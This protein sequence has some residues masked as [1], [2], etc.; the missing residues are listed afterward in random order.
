MAN[1]L[2]VPIV[3]WGKKPPTHRISSIVITSDLRTVVTGC[4]DGQ[5][6]VWDYKDSSIIP[7]SLLFGHSSC[8]VSIATLCETSSKR[9]IISASDVGELCMWDIDDG[10]CIEQTQLPG[11]PV[12][13]HCCSFMLKNEMQ[14]CVMCYGQFSEICL[15]DASSLQIILNL[16]SRIFPD[17]M[18]AVVV[19]PYHLT[20]DTC[21]IIG[22]TVSGMLKVWHLHKSFTQAVL[23]EEES[24]QI[25]SPMA[26]EMKFSQT[27]CSLLI[28]C[29]N[30]WL[31]CD[32][33]DYSTL[34]SEKVKH[35]QQLIGGDFLLS[36]IIITWNR[37]GKVR[38]YKLPFSGSNQESFRSSLQNRPKDKMMPQQIFSFDGVEKDQLLLPPAALLLQNENA[39]QLVVGTCDGTVTIAEINEDGAWNSI[40]SSMCKLW[41]SLDKKPVGIIDLL[42]SESCQNQ[43][44]TATLYISR[45][46]YLCCG[47]EN[48]TI[49]VV[50]AA[51][52]CRAHLCTDAVD[53]K[54]HISHRTLFGHHDRV[55]S[56]LYPF[57]E[58]PETYSSQLLV[59]GSAD[60]SVIL[61][62]LFA[63]V[64][65]HSFHIH[66]G[67]ITQLLVPPLGCNSRIRQS[68]CSVAQDH[69]VAL[70]NL[71]D[72]KCILMASRHPSPITAIRWRPD[73]DFLV[74]SCADSSVF[75][76]QMETGH[77]D[78]FEQGTIAADIIKAC[79]EITSTKS[80]VVEQSSI[81]LSQALK[82]RSLSLFKAVAQQGLRSLIEG[83]ESHKHGP[84]E[85]DRV[86]NSIKYICFF[87][88]FCCI[89]RCYTLIAT[90]D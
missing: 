70:L 76:W 29:S 4:R 14:N 71:R 10:R 68:V 7:K 21:N 17:W 9:Q 52:T 54:L 38:L 64:L 36:N 40:S 79:D 1:S 73:D 24:K 69:S 2:I 25:H 58:S 32:A 3:L 84:T 18:A 82:T 23:F 63:G 47:C 62:D 8:V 66:G 34:C 49:V 65:I 19:M 46:C 22:L 75:V 31:I 60:F 59:S 85:S 37:M 33:G 6:L 90:V 67:E 27:N 28:I 44:I 77:L 15:L 42:S 80:N 35:G 81:N 88:H 16:A 78:R 41:N 83:L 5:L 39:S 74:V 43:S 51:S 55:T 87:S 26:I 61:W 86:S 11:T 45:Y 30:M 20:H 50:P 53:K 56:L 12:Q 72:R 89:C 13:V 57:Q 48:G